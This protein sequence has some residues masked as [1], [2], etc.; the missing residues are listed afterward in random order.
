MQAG[1]TINRALPIDYCPSFLVNKLY[2][3][4]NKNRVERIADIYWLFTGT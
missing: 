2:G 1:G 3:F 4:V